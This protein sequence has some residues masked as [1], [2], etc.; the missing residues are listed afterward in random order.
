MRRGFLLGAVSSLGLICSTG[1]ASAKVLRVPGKLATIQA[2]V[3]A[4]RDGDEIQVQPGAYCGATI[5]KRVELVG[6]GHPRIVGC[7]GSP[8]LG[9]ARVGFYLPGPNGKNPANGSKISGFVFD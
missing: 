2:A 4:A 7:A 8:T 5:N 9:L 1:I 6:I 3:D